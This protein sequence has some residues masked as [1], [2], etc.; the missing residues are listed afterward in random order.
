MPSTVHDL[1]DEL[2]VVDLTALAGEQGPCVSFYL[3]AG[4]TKED[5]QRAP[6][7]LRAL[8]DDAETTL[9]ETRAQ[10]EAEQ[11]LQGVHELLSDT[12]FWNQ[13]GEGL[14]IIVCGGQTKAIR[15]AFDPGRRVAVGDDPHLV[16]LIDVLEHHG[17]Y[18]VLAM[19]LGRVRLFSGTWASLESIDLGPIPESVEEMDRRHRVEPQ[20]QHQP[21]PASRGA[22]TF[23]G[24]GGR[25]VSDVILEKFVSEV[26]HG[27][28]TRLGAAS[29]TPLYLASVQE[30]LPLLQ[31]TGQLP[32]LRPHMITGNP[33]SLAV[34][35]LLDRVR[36]LVKADAHDA[37]QTLRE[38]MD[39]A[40]GRG[41]L[42]AD[43]SDL[44]RAA[45]EGR[46]NTLVV[47]ASTVTGPDDRIDALVSQTLQH[48]GQVRTLENLP[49]DAPVVAMLRY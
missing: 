15:L 12:V 24:H 3:P 45:G 5:A 35:E 29:K 6:L 23:H 28:R 13:Q 30:Y 25:D 2:D 19:S 4:R 17:P 20:L 39:G 44:Q 8:L 32:M 37:E 31:A 33:D 10:D 1:V 9:R 43:R 26:S 21:Q 27:V 34:H 11:M 48:G 38:Q 18:H 22:A 40:T 42:T 47:D 7:E 46:I 49:Q 36:E 14:A 41:Q 16:P